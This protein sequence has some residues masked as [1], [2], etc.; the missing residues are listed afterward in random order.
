MYSAQAITSSDLAQR[1][2]QVVSDNLQCYHCGEVVPHGVLLEVPINGE[3]RQMCCAGCEAVARAIV[4]LGLDNYYRFR[5]EKASRPEELLPEELRK[6]SVFDEATMQE[7]LVE[8]GFENARGCSILISDMTCPAC[9]WLVQTRLEKIPGIED[10]H[11]NYSTQRARLCWDDSR[12]KLSRIMQHILELGYSAQLHN[13]AVALEGMRQEQAS[14]LRRL[15]L[16]GVLGMQVMMLSIAM[17]VGD[18]S[19]MQQEHRSFFS[20]LCLLLT[21]PVIFYSAQSFFL[22]AWR[23]IRL[24]RTGMDVPVSLGISIAYGASAW[25]TIHGTGEIYYDSVVMFTFFLLAARYVEFNGRRKAVFHVDKLAGSTAAVANRLKGATGSNNYEVIPARAL[26]PGDRVLVRAGE[27]VPADGIVESGKTFVDESLVS[28]ESCPVKRS[29]GEKLI[30]GSINTGQPV[31]MNVIATGNDTVR[32]HIFRLIE[33]GQEIKPGIQAIANHV[34]A[35]FVFTVLLLAMGTALYWFPVQSA[36]WIAISVS[37]LVVSCPCALSLATPLA[38]ASASSCLMSRGIVLANADVLETLDKVDHFVFDK[39]GTL[40]SPESKIVDIQPCS[41]ISEKECLRIAASMQRYSAHPLARAFT[42]TKPVDLEVDSV[43]DSPSRGLSAIINGERYFLGNRQHILEA[44]H[45]RQEDLAHAADEIEG[46]RL[47]YLATE[48]ELVCLFRMRDVEYEA[49]ASLI[50][51]LKSRGKNVSILSG[52]SKAPTMK[53]AAALG[54][55]SARWSLSPAQKMQ[56]VQQLQDQG[57]VVVM[58]GDGM[59][60]APVLASAGVSIAMGHGAAMASSNSDVVLLN[61]NISSIRELIEIASTTRKVI[62]QN[63]VWALSYNLL[64]LPLAICGW[65]APWI[66]AIGMSASSLLV[67][68]NSSRIVARGKQ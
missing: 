18:S 15:G 28:G 56:Q 43:I 60:D 30:G 24:L 34:S 51:Y 23:D 2:A 6:L 26:N 12:I 29:A 68:L 19:G 67:L 5:N 46:D 10:I 66:A 41:L 36:D 50:E 14:Q 4:D 47:I 32:A 16:A 42:R 40:V 33:R 59:N 58:V 57:K 55:N 1:R 37:V 22:R 64:V 62:L 63:L 17:Y 13:P 20:W 54:I 52:D 44:S 8:P 21:T 31:V 25:S 11:V 39:T 7:G 61:D 65:I 45:V 53:A 9:A 3:K 48:S 35:Y 49:S 27:V 38:I